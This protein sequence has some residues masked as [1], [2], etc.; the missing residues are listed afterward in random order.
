M[1]RVS[2]ISRLQRI[3]VV[4][5]PFKVLTGNKAFSIPGCDD[6]QEVKCAKPVKLEIT[7]K[8]EDGQRLYTHK[9]VYRTCEEDIDVDTHYAYLVT[10]IESRRYLIGSSQ[11]PFPT[12]T[13]A[14]SHPDSLTSS[15]LTEVSV[16]WLAKRKAPKII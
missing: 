12:I 10:D 6:W 1:K 13:V 15:S 5:L 16:Q 9:L 2:Y 8:V 7:D 4:Q 14:E 3:P 11:R